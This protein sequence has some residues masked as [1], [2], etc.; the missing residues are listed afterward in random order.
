MLVAGLIVSDSW[1][2]YTN[3]VRFGSR[4]VDLASLVNEGNFMSLEI[5]RPAA[6]GSAR[7][8]LTPL[9]TAIAL[10]VGVWLGVELELKV[11]YGRGVEAGS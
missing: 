10:I 4:Q 9:G 6:V 5:Y 2:T 11:V 7:R 8:A 1:R 3:F